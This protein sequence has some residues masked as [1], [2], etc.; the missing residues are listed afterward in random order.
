MARRRS[1]RKIDFTHWTGFGTGS[2]AQATG[3]D[4]GITLFAAQ[5]LPET[6]LRTR[7]N[8]VAY[9]DGVQAPG[10]VQRVSVG[11]IVVPEGTGTTVLWSPNSDEDAPWL[12]YNSFVLGHEEQVTDVLQYAGL[13]MLRE[14]IDSKAMRILK[15]E[16]VQAVFSNATAA[17]AGTAINAF[18]DGRSLFGT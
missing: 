8:L 13:G 12:Y 14:V 17:G 16:E 5:H 18:V 2:V 15:N 9:L 7:G 10:N 4:A 3:T 6:L 1:G 11:F